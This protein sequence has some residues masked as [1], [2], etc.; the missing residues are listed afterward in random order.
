METEMRKRNKYTICK[1]YFKILILEML[2][3]DKDFFDY[4]DNSDAHKCT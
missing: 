4:N 3:E 2:K 1:I